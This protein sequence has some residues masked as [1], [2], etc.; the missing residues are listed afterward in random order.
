MNHPI[1]QKGGGSI[2]IALLLATPG[3]GQSFECIRSA[4]LGFLE[5][6]ERKKDFF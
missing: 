4:C 6:V 5:I 1:D 3:D 2:N